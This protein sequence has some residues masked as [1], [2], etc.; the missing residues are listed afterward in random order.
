MVKKML[1]ALS[2]IFS[3]GVAIILHVK[4]EAQITE[5]TY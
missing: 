4:E 1:L 3:T 2:W 5:M